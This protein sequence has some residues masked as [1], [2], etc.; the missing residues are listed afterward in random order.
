MVSEH[1]RVLAQM[2]AKG[3]DIES[4]L[5]DPF[6]QML[7]KDVVIS[8]FAVSI[9]LLAYYTAI[10]LGSILFQVVFGFNLQQANSLGN[11]TWGAS[12]VT[13]IVV[14]LLSDRLRVRK[15]FMIV[16]AIL[17]AVAI[18][19][20]S[21]HFGHHTSYATVAVLVSFISIGLGVAF[22]PWMASFSETC[23]DHNPALTANRPG[24]MGPDHPGGRL[25]L[26]DRGA[27]GD[28]HR[29]A[30]GELRREDQPLHEHHRLG[31]LPRLADCPN[32]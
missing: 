10:G 7:K 25:L 9:L 6:R 13:A 23:E 11:W 3:L 4:A 26:V 29:D 1:D 20:Y 16:G 17:T 22:T 15:P 8:G 24:H 30:A 28:H 27:L 31:R 21:S 2:K 12:A 18:A 19:L 32:L 14:G 5:K